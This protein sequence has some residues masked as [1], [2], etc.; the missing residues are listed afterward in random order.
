MFERRTII[1]CGPTG[2]GKS[3][4][5]T[6]LGRLG[7]RAVSCSAV[8][9]ELA[10]V[11]PTSDR[12]VALAAGQSLLRR[13][14]H[15]WF[16]LKVLARMPRGKVVIDGPRPIAVAALLAN[17][18]THAVVVYVDATP[19]ELRRR[20]RERALADKQPSIRRSPLEKR[21]DRFS[22]TVDVVLISRPR[23]AKLAAIHRDAANLARVRIRASARP[24]R[25]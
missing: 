11:S 8:V 12:V 15:L 6:E 21:S 14:G 1:L 22:E 16:A 24:Q 13:K 20:K 7:Y 4:L 17:L 23:A 19:G 5:A 18:C 9:R 2:A 10:Q 3:T 25:L